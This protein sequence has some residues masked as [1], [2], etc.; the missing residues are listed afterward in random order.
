[1]NARG[2]TDRILAKMEK[3]IRQ[4]YAQAAKETTD[5]LA[6]YLRRFEVK[7]GIKRDQLKR[8][9]ITKRDYQEWRKNQML[10]GKRWAE[11]VDTLAHDL[12]NSDRIAHSVVE[13]YMPEVYALNH[14]FATYEVEKAAKVDTSY[15]LY[16]RQAVERIVRENPKMLPSP[17]KV[18]A[19]KI[20]RGELQ[21]WNERRIESVMLQ[22]IL[23]GESIPQLSKRMYRVTGGNY[24][25]AIRNA[26]TMT[27]GAENAGHAD[28]YERARDMGIEVE[29]FWRATLDSRTRDSHRNLDGEYRDESGYFSNGL[30]Y[31]GDPYGAP[32]EVYNC[33]CSLG[34]NIKGYRK[35]RS[36]TTLRES[37]KLGNMTYDEWKKAH[38]TSQSITHQ[39]EIARGMK[40]RYIREDYRR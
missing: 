34:A 1:M 38:G 15:T 7:D 37:S 36:D 25:D 22:G 29:E 8:G 19:E 31:P 40:W 4:E 24:K 30:K 11:Q 23:Q 10:I 17:G 33:R 32:E 9:V 12:S 21:A 26:R 39:E 35:D 28:A 20:A 18:T 13:G 5:K 16:N 6:D 14:D 27:T 2:Q 3:R